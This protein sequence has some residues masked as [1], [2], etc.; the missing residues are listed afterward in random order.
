MSGLG[1]QTVCMLEAMATANIPATGYSIRYDYGSFV[2]SLD[3][4]GLQIEVP[5]FW[6]SKG[7]PWEIARQDV[8]YTI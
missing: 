7:N 2:Q 1:R 3:T 4:D 5:D 8:C 6:I